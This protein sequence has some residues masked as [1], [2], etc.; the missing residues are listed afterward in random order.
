[1]E[2]MILGP[3]IEI[4]VNMTD[5]KWEGERE[6]KEL[7]FPL[8]NRVASQI[9][10]REKKSSPAG[11]YSISDYVR[12]YI[13]ITERPGQTVLGFILQCDA[14]RNSAWHW[15]DTSWQPYRASMSSTSMKI[16][17]GHGIVAF[18][19]E[20]F[21]K[22]T[23]QICTAEKS[24]AGLGWIGTWNLNNFC[25]SCIR[26]PEKDMVMRKK[27][28]GRE[29]FAFSWKTTGFLWQNWVLSQNICVSKRNFLEKH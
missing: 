18:H 5:R 9:K 1:M 4:D 29:N 2:S 22:P 19:H 23:T 16:E 12:D 15:P 17:G 25:I 6:S 3:Q 26:S 21:N 10:K 13:I 27:L 24:S 8:V 14:K 7:L 28:D 20:W 11:I